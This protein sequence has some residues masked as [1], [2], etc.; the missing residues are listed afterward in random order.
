LSFRSHDVAIFIPAVLKYQSFHWL[1]EEAKLQ[2]TFHQLKN[3]HGIFFY[4]AATTKNTLPPTIA[5]IWLLS[6]EI[7]TSAPGW[8][9]P[10]IAALF[11]ARWSTISFE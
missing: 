2:S 1:R 3:L 4:K 10:Q 5:D 11:G 7:L 8:P 9:Y 6:Y